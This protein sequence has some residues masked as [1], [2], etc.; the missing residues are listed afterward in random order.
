MWPSGMVWYEDPAALPDLSSLISA[1]CES[2]VLLLFHLCDTCATRT[3]VINK[4][5]R[6]LECKGDRYAI[7]RDGSRLTSIFLT[8]SRKSV[9]GGS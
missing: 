6:G 5:D 8:D 3:L 2:G 9:A 1:P 7:C 4:V